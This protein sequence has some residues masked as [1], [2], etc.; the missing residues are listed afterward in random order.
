[1]NWR[2]TIDLT[3]VWG[4]N[5]LS[6]ITENIVIGLKRIIP[7]LTG[8]LLMETNDLLEATVDL[9]SQPEGVT[10]HKLDSLLRELYDWGD[11]LVENNRKLCWIATTLR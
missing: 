10:V 1:M 3:Q 11:T 8:D 6:L 5:D 9:I 4:S 7:S 2:Y